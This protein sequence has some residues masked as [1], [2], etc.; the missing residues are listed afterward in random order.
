MWSIAIKKVMDYSTLKL[1]ALPAAPSR[2]SC[3]AKCIVQLELR[4]NDAY[5]LRK[6]KV[7]PSLN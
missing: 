6:R 1:S 3:F 4:D 5:F 2:H 7:P